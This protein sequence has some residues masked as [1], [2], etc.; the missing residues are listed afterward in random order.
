MC[1]A[2]KNKDKLLLNHCEIEIE[3]PVL[4]IGVD[5]AWF[6]GG[7]KNKESRKETIAWSQKV[8]GDWSKPEFRRINLNDLAV[9]DADETTPNA[10]PEGKLLVE[11]IMKE[12]ATAEIENVVI[13]L[14]APLLAKERCLESRFKKPKK[15]QVERRDCDKAFGVA[16]SS[17]PK[18]WK[19]P[20]VQPGAPLPSRISAIVA[21]MEENEFSVFQTKKNSPPRL[22]IEC[23]PNEVLWS[24]G[25]QG[26][27]PDMDYKTIAAYKRVGKNKAS[28]PIQMLKEIATLAIE[29][30]VNLLPVETAEWTS[31]YWNW[32]SKDKTIVKEKIG[33][34]GKAFDD[35][36]D[37]L[38]SLV[39]AVSFVENQAHIHEGDPDDGHI[40]GPG[41]SLKQVMIEN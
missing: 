21:K 13:A 39:A 26:E 1:A 6:G 40:I 4:C 14:D 25:V 16:I 23:F 20:K 10:D 9:E 35:S 17:S 24:A 2:R 36:V 7:G 22:L 11:A 32:L 31:A 18:G 29:P 27:C 37:S 19:D 15:G 38:L 33:V 30:C 3:M 34:A 8:G 5:L 28:F 41:R 12:V